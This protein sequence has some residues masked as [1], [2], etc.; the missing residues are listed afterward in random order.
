MDCC[1]IY[2]NLPFSSSLGCD[3]CRAKQ[4]AMSFWFCD[5]PHLYICVTKVRDLDFGTHKER[6]RKPSKGWHILID[7][8][9]QY[10]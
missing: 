6:N 5:K 2:L 9:N 8:Q 1:K 10:D 4:K 3:H 7:D